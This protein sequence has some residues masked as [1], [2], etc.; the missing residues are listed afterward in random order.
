MWLG[1]RYYKSKETLDQIK[2]FLTKRFL[3]I[4]MAT[5]DAIWEVG[6]S[7]KNTLFWGEG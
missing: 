3:R 4:S 5:Q 7:L 1:K 2:I 6:I